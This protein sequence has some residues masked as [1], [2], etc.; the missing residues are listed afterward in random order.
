L[1]ELP[2]FEFPNYPE[3]PGFERPE[4]DFEL[5]PV[6]IPQR[7]YDGFAELR[8]RFTSFLGFEKLVEEIKRNAV[9]TSDFKIVIENPFPNFA[10]LSDFRWRAEICLGELAKQS[11]VPL[12][13]TILLFVIILMFISAVIVVLTRT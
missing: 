2:E 9:F 10:G 11:W 8:D 4:L 1:P 12:I 6:E 7:I 5:L 3:L 13:R